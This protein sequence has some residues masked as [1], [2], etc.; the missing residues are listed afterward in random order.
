M[1]TL[2]P[3]Q[4]IGCTRDRLNMI[5]HV[6]HVGGIAHAIA[7]W[8]ETERTIAAQWIKRS[9]VLGIPAPPLVVATLGSPPSSLIPG[10]PIMRPAIPSARIRNQGR[11]SR[12]RA[13]SH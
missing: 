10:W 4:R 6:G 3:K 11:T 7:C 8:L 2:L 5:G 13:E 9:E 12:P 1:I